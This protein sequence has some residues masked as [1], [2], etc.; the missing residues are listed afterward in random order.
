[1][2]MFKSPRLLVENITDL[3]ISIVVDTTMLVVVEMAERKAVTIKKVVIKTKRN[4]KKIV[5]KVA[6]N[7]LNRR[8][9]I[10]NNLFLII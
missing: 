1:M 6:K 5:K 8:K 2:A 4:A 10:N 9:A 7:S 3:T